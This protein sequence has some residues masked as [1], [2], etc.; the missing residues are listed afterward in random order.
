MR[1][2]SL[3]AYGALGAVAVTS[4]PVY[5]Q[6]STTTGLA[7]LALLLVFAATWTL[8]ELKEQT[9]LPALVLLATTAFAIL[10]LAPSG[11]APILL[12]LLSSLLGENLRVRA[13][14]SVLVAI[15]LG[16]LA[17]FYW[18]WQMSLF[19]SMSMAVAFASFQAF[20]ALSLYYATRSERMAAELRSVNADLL[21]TRSLLSETARDQERL[22]LSRELH[23]IAGHKLTA[24]KLNLRSLA[25]HRNLGD[26]LEL[27]RCASLADELLSDLRSVVQQLRRNDGID[28]AEGI[29][30]LTR[31]LPRPVVRM[32]L[33]PAARVPR[34]EQAEALLRVVQESL[35]NAARHGRAERVW[36]NLRRDG[37][38]LALEVDD[39]GRL[40]WPLTPGNG[41]TGMRERME[42]LG[43]TLEMAPSA[44]GGLRLSA[45]L[46]LEIAP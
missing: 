23:D 31:P 16:L 12:I 5:F 21:A 9:P 34:A 10:L 26:N 8:A 11:T 36:L 37:D 44:R 30:Q 4:V 17:I 14:A 15:N 40:D 1:P 33:D 45:R 39:D 6:H 2:L 29:R 42:L 35:T 41:L 27:K 46:P 43:G 19:Y 38:Q 24:L 25:R 28:L 18:H 32:G 7:A 22:R 20:A 13:M 3:S